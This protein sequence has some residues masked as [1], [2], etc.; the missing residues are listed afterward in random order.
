MWFSHHC[1]VVIATERLGSTFSRS[2]F[3][4]VQAMR[5]ENSASFLSLPNNV[6]LKEKHHHRHEVVETER[7]VM[8]QDTLNSVVLCLDV[9]QPTLAASLRKFLL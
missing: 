2:M 8:M 6:M 9:C 5:I 1:L 3:A 4:I 7:A